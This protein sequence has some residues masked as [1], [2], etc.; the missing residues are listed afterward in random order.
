MIWL[1]IILCLADGTECREKQDF[2]PFLMPMT[3]TVAAQRAAA[4]WLKTD[5]AYLMRETPCEPEGRKQL[6]T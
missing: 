4:E 6:R 2:E 3:C 1:I 5:P